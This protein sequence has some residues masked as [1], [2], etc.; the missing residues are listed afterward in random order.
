M[1]LLNSLCNQSVLRELAGSSWTSEVLPC[2][3]GC[4]NNLDS[5]D[6]QNLIALKSSVLDRTVFWLEF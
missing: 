2:S 5:Y 1:R 4:K 6:R 3:L